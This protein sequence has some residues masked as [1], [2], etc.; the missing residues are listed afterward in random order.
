MSAQVT[1]ISVSAAHEFSKDQLPSI[2]RLAGLGVDGGAH[3]GDPMRA[4]LP[5]NAPAPGI[6]AV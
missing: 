4:E 6:R 2:R 1:A 3:A 5:P